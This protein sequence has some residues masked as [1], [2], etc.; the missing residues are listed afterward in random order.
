MLPYTPLHHLLLAA[1]GPAN[2]MHQRKPL[3]RADGHRHRR[4]QTRL[5][6]IADLLLTHDRPIVRPVDDSIV[7]V[8]PEG[9]CK[10]FAGRGVS[11][12]GRSGFPPQRHLRRRFSPSAAI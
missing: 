10:C 9:A 8:G 4:R 5:G 2:R 1:L 12:R 3:G 6:P 7:R 11:P